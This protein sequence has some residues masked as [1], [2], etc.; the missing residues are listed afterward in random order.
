MRLLL[1][2]GSGKDPG[3]KLSIGGKWFLKTIAFIIFGYEY[4]KSRTSTIPS[5][6]LFVSL[7]FFFI[8]NH[9]RTHLESDANDRNNP[10]RPG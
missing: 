9:M 8:A 1:I 4:G 5:I 7:P 6:Q 3:K 2:L 10:G